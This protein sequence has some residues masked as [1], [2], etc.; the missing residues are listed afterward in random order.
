MIPSLPLRVLT[1]I[2]TALTR[3][4]EVFAALDF[5]LAVNPSGVDTFRL[6]LKRQYS[7]DESSMSL[8]FGREARMRAWR[9]RTVNLTLTSPLR[10]MEKAI[11]ALQRCAP[12]RA[13]PV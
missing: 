6:F 5:R 1:R 4:P 2:R 10:E 7:V 12:I 9:A 8:P 3:F 13:F 11:V